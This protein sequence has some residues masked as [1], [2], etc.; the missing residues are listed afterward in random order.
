MTILRYPARAIV[1]DLVRAAGGGGACGLILAAADPPVWLALILWAALLA[2][3]V[4]GLRAGAR[5]RQAF[6]ITQDALHL[7]HRDRQ[8]PWG[9]LRRLRLSYFSTRRDHREG[10][11]E[12]VLGFDDASVRAD[13]RLQGFEAL[14]KEAL[15]AAR[16]N[17]LEL[18]PATLR[19]LEWLGLDDVIPADPV[20]AP[21][22][23]TGGRSDA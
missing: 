4:F 18:S 6:T 13:S 19:N 14:L 1:A 17:G 20:A 11:L 23:G 9:S 16:H 22:P 15:A 3:V 2:F 21:G 12:L 10:W 8:V 7:V 5:G